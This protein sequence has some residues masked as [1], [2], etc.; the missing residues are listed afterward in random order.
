M[1]VELLV[2]LKV[3]G[4]AFELQLVNSYYYQRK[5]AIDNSLNLCLIFCNYRF[6]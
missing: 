2:T 5:P 1:A 6:F 3:N 4:K